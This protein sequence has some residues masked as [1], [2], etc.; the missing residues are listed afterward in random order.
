MNKLEMCKRIADIEGKTSD[1]MKHLDRV[2]KN[3]VNVQPKMTFLE[4]Y[5]P[6]A[7]YDLCLKLMIKY[8]ISY[9]VQFVLGDC[10]EVMYYVHINCQ[11]ATLRDDLLLAV[12]ETI[13][14]SRE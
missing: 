2:N 14:E 12:C 10:G 11:Y 1:I 5:N 4:C 9:E 13:I 8:H 3:K 7:D 6:R